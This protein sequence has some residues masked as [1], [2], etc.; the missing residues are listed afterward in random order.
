[1]PRALVVLQRLRDLARKT[2][3]AELRRAEG[4]RDRQQERV[5]LIADAMA[6]A[7]AAC[8]AGDLLTLDAYHSFR[9]QGEMAARREDT[10]L[11][12]RSREVDARSQRHLSTVRDQLAVESLLRQRDEEDRIEANRREAAQMDEI[13]SRLRSHA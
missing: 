12:H 10:R 13:G 5:D 4:E 8:G 3:E 11:H 6:T 1:M 2:A 7:R 9:L